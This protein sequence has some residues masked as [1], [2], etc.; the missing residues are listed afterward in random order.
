MSKLRKFAN[1]QECTIRHP[2]YC[3]GD[4]TTT[5]L[6]HG[7]GAGFSAKTADYIGVHGCAGCHFWLDHIASRDEYHEY[8]AP[9]LRITLNRAWEEG[10]I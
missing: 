5:V 8:F 9:A 1:D 7:K 6:C 2:E 10:L 4:T 3:N